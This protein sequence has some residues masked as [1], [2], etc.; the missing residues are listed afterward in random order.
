MTT[1]TTHAA[2]STMLANMRRPSFAPTRR[3]SRYGKLGISFGFDALIASRR[4]PSRR[5]M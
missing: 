4:A 2:C 1:R 5:V 3:E